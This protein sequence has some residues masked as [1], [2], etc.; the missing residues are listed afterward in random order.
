MSHYGTRGDLARGILHITVENVNRLLGFAKSGM[1]R[2]PSLASCQ[3]FN[4]GSFMKN[5]LS[6][7]TALCAVAL[8][9]QAA[10][11]A[12]FVETQAQTTAGQD[13]S[14]IFAGLPQP[15]AAGT[16]TFLIRGDFSIGASLGESFAFDLEGILTGTDIQATAGNTLTNFNF[17]D[18]LFQTSFDLSLAQLAAITADGVANLNVDYANGV[19][20]INP[21]SSITATLAFGAVPEPAT[22][23]FMIF[24]FGAIGGAMRRQRKA[25]VKVSYA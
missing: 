18:N 20:I 9:P 16:L 25:N 22:W 21:N 7:A 13:F 4:M 2:H 23:A 6:A 15:N 8:A 1:L 14:F 24:G 19:N 10:Q 12:E 17:D 11:A 3:I 5:Y